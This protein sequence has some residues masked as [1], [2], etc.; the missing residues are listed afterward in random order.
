MKR[1]IILIVFFSLLFQ[2][3]N[4]IWHTWC[5]FVVDGIAYK[6]VND[7]TVAVTYTGYDDEYWGMGNSYRTYEND[8]YGDIVIPSKVAYNDTVYDVKYIT[9]F[10]FCKGRYKLSGN[11]ELDEN[12]YP[13]TDWLGVPCENTPIA[14]IFIPS[15]IDS[16]GD[17]AFY[18]NKTLE[19][20]IFEDESK[21]P[22]L[23]E[24][25][26]FYSKWWLYPQDQIIINGLMIR[27][28]SRTTDTIPD[29]VTRILSY[30]CYDNRLT[31]IRIPR[32][33]RH[34]ESGAFLDAKLE[35]LIIEESDSTC[36]FEPF[37][38][39]CPL[40][41]VEIN[42]SHF[43][44]GIDTTKNTSLYY[45]SLST[46]IFGEKV[47]TISPICYNLYNLTEITIPTNAKLIEHD[48]FYLDSSG[49]GKGIQKLYYNAI[50]CDFASYDE[51]AFGDLSLKQVTIG[52]NV[53]RLP[54]NFLRNQYSLQEIV[55]PSQ[56]DTI[57][58]YAFNNCV[59]LE[60][61]TSLRP[62]PVEIEASVF[63]GVDKQLCVLY[64]PY[65]SLPLY[66]SAPVWKSF[67]NI[68]SIRGDVNGDDHVNVS[69]VAALIN[70]ILGIESMNTDLAD[71]NGD[72]RVNV[73]DVAALINIILGI[74]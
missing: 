51:N 10:A 66:R 43:C 58:A 59:K 42:A 56:V 18:Y 55:L 49:Q 63:E 47:Q 74:Q 17:Y 27:W 53:R 39:A 50:S 38:I 57:G 70:Q 68:K 61:I 67:L 15:S 14:S 72:G 60:S 48:A 37:A 54:V 71:V 19:S 65:S 24:K 28:W 64:V 32:T 7:S 52:K 44:V 40:K 30:A 8:Y 22:K 5:S 16:I 62:E 46:V 45:K 25:V 41:C 20:V 9:D 12:V 35:T 23:G 33:V 21:F 34:V 3:S 31:T 69:D 13:L 1:L 73:S 29:N 11:P 36:Y 6:I 26:F 4:A 2:T